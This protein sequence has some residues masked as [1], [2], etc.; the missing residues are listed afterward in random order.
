MK[1]PTDAEFR[2]RADAL[3]EAIAADVARGPPADRRRGHRRHDVVDEHRPGRR[4]RRRL[5]RARHVAARRR[6]LRRR[7]GGRARAAARAGRLRAGRLAGREP[8]QVAAHAD[9]LQPALHRAARR[10]AG[11][12]LGRPR[13]PALERG[14]RRQPDGLRRR[15]RAAGSARSSCGWCCAPTAP[16]ACAAIVAGHV[17][18]A[19]R[20]EAAIAAEPGW[21]LLAPVPFSTVCFRH[22]PDGR[23]RRGRAA[24]RTTRPSSSA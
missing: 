6:G 14:R 11:G 24:A 19:R 12:V 23:R 9:R 17:E 7:R 3:R 10:P 1:I 5:R 2:M 4:R 18:L 15:A 8:A 22:H 21:E 16:R 20:L 13:V